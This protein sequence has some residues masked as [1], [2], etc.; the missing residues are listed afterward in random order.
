MLQRDF[1]QSLSTNLLGRNERRIEC[2]A[3]LR[4]RFQIWTTMCPNLS[5]NFWRDSSSTCHR[6]TNEVDVIRCDRLVIYCTLKCFTKVSKLLMDLGGSP[7]YQVNATPLRDVGKKQHKIA[8]SLVYK[9][10]S[11]QMFI[12]IGGPIIPL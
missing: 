7:S 6:L 8:L 10:F 9:L 2:S 1:L 11:I 3:T 4:L 12:L 5:M